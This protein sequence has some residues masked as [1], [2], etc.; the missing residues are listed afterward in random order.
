M[1]KSA[2]AAYEIAR[3]ALAGAN[4]GAAVEAALKAFASHF[5]DIKGIEKMCIR[6]RLSTNGDMDIAKQNLKAAV[7][8]NGR[9][10][11]P[12]FSCLLYTSRCV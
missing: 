10:I 9:G 8:A 11:P 4:D 5:N 7:E 2:N 3:D 12:Y 6:D 1:A